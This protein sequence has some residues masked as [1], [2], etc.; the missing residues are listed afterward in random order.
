MTPVARVVL[1]VILIAGAGPAGFL[2]YRLFIGGP[3]PR[4][5]P[6]TQPAAGVPREA[7]SAT[8][9]PH[10]IPELL[11]DVTLPDLKGAPRK[12]SEWRGRPLMVNFW[13]TWCEP[14]RR[15]IPLLESLRREPAAP[16][17]EVVGIAV[18]F[19]KDV[20]PFAQKLGMDYP[21]LVGEQ[22]GLKAVDA[23]GVPA[24]FPF[25]VFADSGG[26]IVTLKIGE[27]H[28]DEARLILARVTAVDAGQ[29]SL[30]T[31]REQISAGLKELAV[32]RAQQQ[33]TPAA[34]GANP[35]KS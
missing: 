31:A 3:L 23:F 8:P 4:A 9:Q 27:L 13:A 30:A 33:Q 16:R 29:L 28:P 25:T 24:V 20:Q 19:A 1:G 6:T 2:M 26:H 35:G 17:L 32:T 11:P 5:T 14:C 7:S 21:I 10:A 15:E 18:D 34:T 22:D 12:L